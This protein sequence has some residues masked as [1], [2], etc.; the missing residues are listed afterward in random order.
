LEPSTRPRLT[1]P[2]PVRR[3]FLRLG[4]TGLAGLTWPGLLRLRAEVGSSRPRA[5][6]ALLVVW[7]HGG[8]SHLETYDPKPDAPAEY[9]GPYRPIETSVPG[10]RVSELLPEH[11]RVA[12][13]FTLLRSLGHTGPCHD[14]G[15]Q[16]LFTSFPITVNKLKPDHPDLFAIVN[17]L[18][19]DPSRLLPNNIGVPPIPY[20]GSAYLGPAHE[21]FAVHGD[22]N[23]PKFEVPNIGLKDPEQVT[24]LDGRVRLRDGLD[25][26]SRQTDTLARRD[27][28]DEFRGQALNVLTGPQAR[29]AFDLSRED[30]RVRDRYGRNAWGQRCLLARRLVETGVDLVSV[31]LNGPLCGRVGNWDDH[32]VNHHVFDA[33]KYRTPFFDRAVSALVEDLHDRGLDERVLLVVGGDFGRTPKISYAASTGG[34]VASGAEGVTQPGRDHW[35]HAMSFLFSGGRIA[36]G[37]VIGATD[38]LGERPKDRRVGVGDFLATLYRHLGVD[39]E[40]ESV[41]GPDGRPVPLLQQGGEPIRELTPA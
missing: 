15:P 7:L 39:A 20:L 35:P 19:A 6:T 30:P 27:G 28:F 12:H 5:D 31:A 11:A 23:D 17:R 24:R 32:A 13:R 3:E 33:M 1:C 29:R 22:P 21:P 26:L 37:Q 9:R 10:L 36:E 34:G 18:R 25:R 16:Q 41:R 8:A 14:S 4:L 40:R 2:G 38:R